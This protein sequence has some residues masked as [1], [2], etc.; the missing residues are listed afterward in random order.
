MKWEADKMAD[1]KIFRID[2]YSWYVAHNLMEFLNWYHKRFSNIDEPEQLEMLE[3]FNPE[4]GAMWSNSNIT[5][6]DIVALGEYEE[7]CRGGIGDLRRIGGEIFKMQTFADVLGDEDI[8]EP[9]EIAST[10]W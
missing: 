1:L 7:V 5:T 2:D 6:D 3:M 8:N 10:E 4:D 9:Y